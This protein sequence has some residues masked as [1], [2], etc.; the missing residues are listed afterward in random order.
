MYFYKINDEVI[1]IK[2]SFY[3]W[4]IEN[5]RYDLIE[6]WNIEKNGD[7]KKIG[8]KSKKKCNFTINN[9]FDD[10]IVS[11][12]DI[13]TRKGCDPMKKYYNSLGYYIINDLHCDDIQK[14]WSKLNNCSPFN[15]A[16]GST[17][18]YYFCCID[19]EYHD[20]YLTTPEI[21][22]HG[23]KCPYCTG[24]LVHPKDSFGYYQINYDNNF[25]D[26]YWSDKNIIDPFKILPYSNKPIYIKCQNNNSHI[27]KISPANFMQGRRCPYCCKVSNKVT[28]DESL[29]K[30]YPDI[31]KIWSVKNKKS[32]YEYRP[33]SHMKVW[34]KC[35]NG[36]HDDYLKIISDYTINQSVECPECVK[37]RTRSFLEEKVFAY[38][39]SLNY[40]VLTEYDCTLIAK[41]PITGYSLPYDN[42]VPDLKLIIEVNGI[43]HY[44][45][46]GFHITQSKKGFKTVEEEFNYQKYKDSV[47]KEFAIKHGYNFMEIPYWAFDDNNSYQEMINQEIYKIQYNTKP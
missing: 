29:G 1:I 5:N 34:L 36:I 12:G 4:C 39:T 19:T 32:P 2:K 38:L 46:S 10:I 17:K 15:I 23:S 41:N 20:D 7:I 14:Y 44:E 13:V 37:H 28:K 40:N 9:N 43:Q 8:F 6:Y 27:Y 3:D 42:E 35:K 25:I 18:K 31:I 47:K 16:K 45:I 30:L 24:K 33:K 11:L 26:K 22:T 21:F